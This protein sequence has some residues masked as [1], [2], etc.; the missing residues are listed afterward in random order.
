[1]SNCNGVKE[2]DTEYILYVIIEQFRLEKTLK[3]I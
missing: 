2:C 1:M 3:I